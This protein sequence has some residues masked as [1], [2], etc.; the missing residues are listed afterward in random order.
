[1]AFGKQPRLYDSDA[2]YAGTTDLVCWLNGKRYIID[3]KT[4]GELKGDAKKNGYAEWPLQTA[5]YRYA[6][7]LMTGE[8]LDG[9][10]IV[11]L[12]KETG[13]MAFFDYSDRYE[14]SW[15][16]FRCLCDFWH[17]QNPDL[18]GAPSVTTITGQLDKSGPLTWWAVNSM[19]EYC[20]SRLPDTPLTV[21]AISGLIEEGRKHFRTVSKTATDIGTAVHAA[22]EAYLKS[23]TEPSKDVPDQVLSG[24]IAFLDWFHN[25]KVEVIATEKVVYGRY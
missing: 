10:A 11:C 12:S 17:L 7:G 21:D 1:M 15:K 9:N 6:E 8:P 22:I 4:A 14:A 24:F 2:Q 16:S 18:S 23:W 25:N 3:F 19:R 5:A 13:L 20:L